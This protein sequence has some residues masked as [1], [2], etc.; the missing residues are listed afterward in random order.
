VQECFGLEPYTAIDPDQAVALG[1]AVQAAILSGTLRGALLLDVIPLSLG[2]ETAG[3]AFAKLIARNSAVPAAAKETFS[4][5]VD[6]QTGI[7]LRVLQGEREMAADCRTIAEM[8]VTGL[9]PMPAGLPQLEVT[10]Q[11]DAN[12]VLSVSAWEKRSGK[13]ASLQVVPN[14]GLTKDEA[15]R[16]EREAIANVREDMARHRVI[17][18]VANAS[19]DVLAIEKT[20][21]RAGNELSSDEA[22]RLHSALDRVRTIIASAKADWR[23]VN[24]DE[25]AKAKQDMD[26]ASVRLHELAISQSLRSQTP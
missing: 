21:A 10:F 5:G 4:T 8:H 17:D 1:A 9:P 18:L 26:V 7:R 13:R 15:D 24:A 16:L 20:L 6:N 25:F 2:I 11:V 19:L 22:Q 3:G 14:H 23:A 12:G